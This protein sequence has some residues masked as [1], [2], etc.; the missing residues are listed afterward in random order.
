MKRDLIRELKD[1]ISQIL[2][3]VEKNVKLGLRFKISL[4]LRFLSPIISII[5][6]I[7]VLGQLFNVS[8]NENFGPWNKEN[9]YVFQ[10]VMYQLNVMIGVRSAFPGHLKTEKIWK[11]LQA[12]IIA[13][14][15]RI[16][17]LLGLFITHFVL[18]SF[19]FLLFFTMCYIFYP[20]SFITVLG[21]FL[22]YFL[23]ALSFSGI[24]LILGIFS[25]S[26]ENFVG[27]FE[28]G[29]RLVF[30]FSALSLPFEF[31][32]E[33]IQAIMNYN[34]VYYIINLARLV[35]IE[36]NIIY[37]FTTHFFELCILITGAILLPIIGLKTFNYI[38]DKYGIVGY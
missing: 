30:I 17:L 19:G 35:W 11:T 14:F 34:P 16:N 25:I 27:V 5:M 10:F 12:L 7:I 33:H 21:E 1:N 18:S 13:P 6:P 28:L 20:I 36:D 3:I 23:F 24:G 2:A 15:N 26:K 22:I 38:F 37:S 9:F 32:P 8:F 4:V 31:F 29:I